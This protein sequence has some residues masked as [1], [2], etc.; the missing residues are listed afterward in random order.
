MKTLNRLFELYRPTASAEA[1]FVDKHVT[2]KHKDRNGNGD[3]VFNAKNIK[4]IKRAKTGQG[5]DAG[6][7]EKVY[8]E[9]EAVDEGY[10]IK[11]NSFSSWQDGVA[12]HADRYTSGGAKH[13]RYHNNIHGS[14][15]DKWR[16]TV[17]THHEIGHM[18]GVFNHKG[19]TGT[20]EGHG[21]HEE[22]HYNEAVDDQA[23]KIKKL[24]AKTRRQKANNN[25]K[26]ARQWD[27][28]QDQVDEAKVPSL[29]AG[30]RL[31]SKHEGSDGY[32]NEVRYNPEWQEYS[33]H[34]FH[35]G[36]HLGEAPVS[37][38]GEGKEGREDATETAE[39]NA[40][41]Y[42][43]KSG[44]VVMKE[45]VESIN[46]LSK[47]TL[48]NYIKKSASKLDVGA[49]SQGYSDHAADYSDS[50]SERKINRSIANKQG[51]KTSNRVVGI[52]RA[53]SKL[54]KEEVESIDELSTKTLKSYI[55]KAGRS[56]TQHDDSAN[57][58]SDLAGKLKDNA[59]QDKAWVSVDQH[60]RKSNSRFKNILKASKKL[61]KED[62]VISAINKYLPE[63]FEVP[64]LEDRLSANIANIPTTFAEAIT[65]LFQDLSEANK[66]NLVET[67]S[68]QEGLNSL[69][70]FIIEGSN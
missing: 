65:T 59:S 9:V 56:A 30:T 47:K 33:V 52:Y 28:S 64:S 41:K 27:N 50:D 67:T 48:G 24:N 19:T 20:E 16:Q 68:T 11:H 37:Y 66:A 14:G 57:F 70:D 22:D 69:V 38:H 32:H 15:K 42:H 29:T 44:K 63:E 26:L 53:S 23:T 46:E 4:T 61:T 62:I 2:I 34:H 40:N 54:T 21:W 25:K 39:H 18:L 8:E 17:A 7:D 5:Y 6:D 10:G 13:V 31:V 51:K 55:K 58:L 45:E 3:D 43:V 36:K 1:D 49:Y 60:M 12:D 35:N